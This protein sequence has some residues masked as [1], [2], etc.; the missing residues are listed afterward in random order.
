M[1]RGPPEQAATSNSHG[2]TGFPGERSGCRRATH[3]PVGHARFA[4]ARAER[5]QDAVRQQHAACLVRR[6]G[7]GR[8]RRLLAVARGH[9]HAARR[10]GDVV[11]ARDASRAGPAGPHMLPSA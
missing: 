8:A 9:H 7:Q 2:R 5:P 6:A 4:R 10:L 11:V 1:T 3:L